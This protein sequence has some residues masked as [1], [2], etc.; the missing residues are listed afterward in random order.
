VICS[1]AHK[2]SVNYGHY[3]LVLGTHAPQE[4][5]PLVREWLAARAAQDAA[6]AS[7]SGES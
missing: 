6:R 1:R 5:Y 2:F 7:S 3:D 4:I